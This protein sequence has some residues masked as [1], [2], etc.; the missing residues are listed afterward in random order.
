[1]KT[2]TEPINLP[3]NLGAVE[4]CMRAVCTRR[5][6][7]EDELLAAYDHHMASGGGRSRARLTLSAAEVL[8]G[9]LV[10]A[11]YLAASVELLHNASLIQDDLQDRS[12]SRRGERAVWQKFGTNTAIGLTDL[13]ISGS[14]LV[15]AD[16]QH[17]DALP[18]LMGRMHDAIAV[19]LRGQTEDLRGHPSRGIEQCLEVAE[20]KSGPLFALS[21]EL[22]LLVAG[23][24]EWIPKAHRAACH[25]G[26]GYQINDDLKD[27]Q[28]D[29]L[30]GAKANVAL[31]LESDIPPEEARQEAIRL[32]QLHLNAARC[33]SESLPHGCGRCLAEMAK[34][35]QDELVAHHG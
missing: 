12:E 5:A 31:L 11:P 30:G 26:L 2:L 3:A 22:P 15:L 20:R 29:L 23:F 17:R 14:Y 33:E 35:V 28:D 9:V 32:A 10:D 13:L 27:S 6:S 16:I 24:T 34:T 8:P 18:A 4:A 25:F 7:P 21:L 19:T 1:M